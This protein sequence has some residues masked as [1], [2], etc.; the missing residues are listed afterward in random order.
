MGDWLTPRPLL[1]FG[2][3]TCTF[4][5]YTDIAN[6]GLLMK[7]RLQCALEMRVKQGF[8][9]AV[10]GIEHRTRALWSGSSSRYLCATESKNNNFQIVANKFII[11][12]VIFMPRIR[13]F[14]STI[15]FLVHFQFILPWRSGP[16]E[17]HIY[18]LQYCWMR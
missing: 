16:W 6:R 7:G 12:V 15:S 13:I 2:V 1:P 9:V 14:S 5:G 18:W 3:C 11:S 17:L 10:L 8:S 4:C